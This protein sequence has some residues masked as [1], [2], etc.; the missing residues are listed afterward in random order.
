M[1]LNQTAFLFN[2]E[3]KIN[4]E[5]ERGRERGILSLSAAHLGHLSLICCS[6]N[7]R[8]ALLFTH[9]IYSG[10]RWCSG[11]V[12]QLPIHYWRRPVDLSWLCSP[13]LLLILSFSSHLIFYFF[14]SFPVLCLILPPFSSHFLLLFLHLSLYYA[15]SFIPISCTLLVVLEV[16]Y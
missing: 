16:F 3:G 5:R 6:L 10:S 2:K 11:G 7:I 8:A 15:F 13:T 4:D 1:T 14:L 12:S 9:F